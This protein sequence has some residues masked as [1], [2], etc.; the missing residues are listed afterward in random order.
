MI[1]S[2]RE[3]SLL[4]IGPIQLIWP[5][6]PRPIESYKITAFITEESLLLIGLLQLIGPIGPR[7][8][9]SY[10]I[11]KYLEKKAFFSLARSN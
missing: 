11:I 9:K 5:I 6:G 8:V 1:A 10:K 2:L 7:P 3:E 4:L